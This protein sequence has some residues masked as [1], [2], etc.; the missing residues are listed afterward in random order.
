V[1]NAFDVE[2]SRFPD[3]SPY[4]KTSQLISWAVGETFGYYTDPDFISALQ[5]KL[6]ETTLLVVI[7]GKFDVGWLRRCGAILMPGIRVWDCQLAEYVLSGQTNSFASME[8]LCERYGI[9]G[10]QGGLEEW[11][12]Q[13]I[14]TRDIPREHVET[15]NLG[16]T[17]RTIQIYH[18]QLADPRMTDKLKKLIL[19]QGL[20]LL[21]LQQMEENGI[22]YDKEGSITK[23]N[24]VQE[25][26]AVIQKEL[27][28]VIQ[29]PHFNLDSNEHLSCFLYGGTIEIDVHE[30]TEL[31]YKSGSRKGET[32]VQNKFKETIKHEFRGYFKP[33][34]RTALKKAGYYQT[35]EPI[36]KQ[37]PAR[38]KGQ[39]FVIERLLKQAELSKQVGSFL[40][41]LPKLID[42][43]EW[44]D[45]II[46]PQYNQCVARTGR[47]SCSKPNAQQWD[48]TT[49][50]YWISRYAG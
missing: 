39:R 29:F 13:G 36:L 15:Y 17:S 27:Q 22:L 25:E 47:L 20:D 11:W 16:D 3:G 41:A 48:E 8:S 10:K 35:G 9:L 33:L 37:L 4:R 38:T 7:N 32:Y 1:I 40:H 49:S 31:V 19:L 24:E 5:E 46:H 50:K 28:D 14:E 42:E 12:G 26:L 45:N 18:A 21:V 6:N 34:P 43:M 23:G 2:S 30:P 44:T